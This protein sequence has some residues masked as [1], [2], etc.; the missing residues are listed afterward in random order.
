MDVDESLNPKELKVTLETYK[1]LA[2]DFANH[3]TI[4]KVRNFSKFVY[5]LFL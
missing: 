5:T 2:N 4:L 3:D 1:K